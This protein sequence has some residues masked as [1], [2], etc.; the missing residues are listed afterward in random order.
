MPGALLEIHVLDEFAVAAHEQVRGNPKMIDGPEVGMG[1]RVQAV[2]KQ[3]VDPG[4]AEDPWRQADAVYDQ[5]VDNGPA[6]ALSW[7]GEGTGRASGSQPC[8]LYSAGSHP[9]KAP[10]VAASG[11]TGWGPYPS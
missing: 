5:Q 1:R 7:L 8:C 6:R 4:P 2:L 9:G 11:L 3:G 10:A